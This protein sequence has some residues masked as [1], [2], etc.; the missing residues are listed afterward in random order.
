M[1]EAMLRAVSAAYMVTKEGQFRGFE[2]KPLRP[3]G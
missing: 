2:E 3:Q 1:N